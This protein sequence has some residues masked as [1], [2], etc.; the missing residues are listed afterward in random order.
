MKKLPLVSIIMPVYNAEKTLNR[1]INSVLLQSYK[2]WELIIINDGSF[3][4]TSFL[5]E[6]YNNDYR[7]IIVNQENH[8]RG[9]SRNVAKNIS[10]GDYIC[11]LDA[12]DY[13]HPLKIEYQVNFLEI[14]KDVDLISTPMFIVFND[15]LLAKNITYE[16]IIIKQFTK[17]RFDV[18]CATSMLRG[19]KARYYSY[20]ERLNCSEDVDFIQR[21]LDGKKYALYNMPLYFYDNSDLSKSKMYNY[22]FESFRAKICGFFIYCTRIC[23][24]KLSKAN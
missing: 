10:R 4:R 9:Y 7:I 11:F 16:G 21:Y 24:D 17:K 20:N 8:G 6:K 14:N 2:N 19:E 12:D 22:A 5:L 18:A 15:R 23:L 1:A 13:I 3:D